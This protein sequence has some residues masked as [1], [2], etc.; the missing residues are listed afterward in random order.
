MPLLEV[1]AKYKLIVITNE[2]LQPT[3]LILW[4]Q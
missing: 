3:E 2:T 1:A 4:M